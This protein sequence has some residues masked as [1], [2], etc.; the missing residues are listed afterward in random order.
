MLNF[1]TG[2]NTEAKLIAQAAHPTGFPSEGCR[3]RPRTWEGCSISSTSCGTGTSGASSTTPVQLVEG[4]VASC[5]LMMLP[6]KN[7]QYLKLGV[8]VAWHGEKSCLCCDD[9][10]QA[11]TAAIQILGSGSICSEVSLHAL[12]LTGRHSPII[13][14]LNLPII[15]LV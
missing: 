3:D 13:Y 6:M 4:P 8:E 14:F 1:P 15:S 5:W 7:D 2:L 9:V 12:E 10:T 11:V